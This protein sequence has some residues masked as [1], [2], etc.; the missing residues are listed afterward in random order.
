MIIPCHPIHQKR[1]VYIEIP[2]TGCTSLK[3][4][5]IP[6]QGRTESPPE[7]LVE[8]HKWFGYTHMH[9]VSQLL[10]QFQTIWSNYYRFTVVRHPI[11]RFESLYYDKIDPQNEH[12]INDFVR[13]HF[14][15]THWLHDSHGSR[16]V[17]LIG[18]DLSVYN[19]VGRTEAMEETASELSSI[20]G[21]LDIPKLNQ[22]AELVKNKQSLH[23]ESIRQLVEIYRLDFKILG[24]SV[25]KQ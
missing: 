15:N 14:L 9:S 2:K 17:D 13:R 23:P 18:R 24:Y 12:D 3:M 16:Q 7:N 10:D 11:R 8:M 1:L 4:A 21:K 20:L 25:S 19:Y 6:F 22:K 5:L